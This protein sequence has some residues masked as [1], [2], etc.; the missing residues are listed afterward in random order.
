MLFRTVRDDRR[1][2]A[3]ALL[4]AVAEEF[5]RPGAV[6]DREPHGIAAGCV[7]AGPA[8]AALLALAFHRR[9][10][11]GAVHFKTAPAQDVLGQVEREAERVVEFERRRARQLLALLQAAEFV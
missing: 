5:R 8:F 2:R 1:H 11:T 10:E 6:A 3:L 7:A 4:G 9:V